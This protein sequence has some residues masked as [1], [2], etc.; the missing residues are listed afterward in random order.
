MDVSNV[1]DCNCQLRTALPCITI[2]EN[3]YILDSSFMF[4][5]DNT[6]NFC[7]EFHENSSLSILLWAIKTQFRQKLCGLILF[8]RLTVNKGNAIYTH[9]FE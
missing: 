6:N 7:F 2:G 9:N 5:K 3:W 1:M 8:S 4:L